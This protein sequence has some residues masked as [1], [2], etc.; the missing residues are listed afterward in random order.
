M[1][2]INKNKVNSEGEIEFPADTHGQVN[3][4]L[5]QVWGETRE[6]CQR[7]ECLVGASGVGLALS[8]VKKPDLVP[9]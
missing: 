3:R 4:G 9:G 6:R 7:L 8:S 1:G 5:F 2:F